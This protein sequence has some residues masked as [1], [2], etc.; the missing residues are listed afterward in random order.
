MQRE[1]ME[2]C[3]QKEKDL[4]IESGVEIVQQQINLEKKILAKER[5]EKLE[6]YK[7][8]EVNTKEERRIIEETK[9]MVNN[10]V[11]FFNFLLGYVTD[12]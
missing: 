2:F 4:M 9:A 5:E 11:S 10:N 3:F 7:E 1:K 12:Q 8:I 6:F